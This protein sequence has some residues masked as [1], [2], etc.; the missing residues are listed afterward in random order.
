M[1]GL[2]GISPMFAYVLWT[3]RLS[4]L[5]FPERRI[6]PTSFPK[7]LLDKIEIKA[8]ITKL[9]GTSIQAASIALDPSIQG[10]HILENYI[11]RLMRRKF[12]RR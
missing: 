5:A 6:P 2:L 4:A 7:S 3:R 12:I 8:S 9:L 10:T 1:H 11:V